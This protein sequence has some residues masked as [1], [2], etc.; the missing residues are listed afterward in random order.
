MVVILLPG[1]I[2]IQEENV[3]LVFTKLKWEITD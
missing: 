1:H 3:S 2:F